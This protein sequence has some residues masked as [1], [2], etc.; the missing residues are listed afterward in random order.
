MSLPSASA[1]KAAK[2]PCPG[3]TGRGRSRGTAGEIRAEGVAHATP[4]GLGSQGDVAGR[5]GG[6]REGGLERMGRGLDSLLSEKLRV[7]RS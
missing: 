5:R 3:H 2:R 1:I 6:T 7:R 4:A